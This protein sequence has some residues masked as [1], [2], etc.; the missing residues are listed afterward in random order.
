[1]RF[2]I[3]WIWFVISLAAVV[4][5]WVGLCSHWSHEHHRVAKTAAILL[6]TA[7]A[8]LAFGVLAYVQL[9]RPLESRT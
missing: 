9:V 2:A 8:L 6:P 7:A 3:A 1:M 5:A 4:F